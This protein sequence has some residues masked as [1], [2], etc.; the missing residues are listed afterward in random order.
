M[1]GEP[2]APIPVRE[3]RSRFAAPALVIFSAALYLG[4]A[5][6]PALVDDDIDAAHAL[7]AREMLQRHDF[8]VPYQDGIR[9]LI[10][11][12]LHF[13]LVAGSYALLGESE[14]ATRLPIAF[15]VVGLVLLTFVFGRRFF[16]ERAGIYGALAIATSAGM[17]VFTRAVIPEALFALELTAVFY[18]FLRSWTGSLDPRLGYRAAAAVCALAVLT[19]GP[20]GVLFPGGAIVLFLT[21][22]GGW[23][24]WR[25]LRIPS[26]VAVFLAIAAPWHILAARR[27]PGFL[28][29]YFVNEHLNRALGTRTPHDYSAVPLWLWLLE[30]FLWLFPWSAFVV[31]LVRAFPRPRTW[32]DESAPIQASLLLFAWAAV[33]LGFFCLEGG[34]RMEYYSFG[35]WPA[36]ALLLG[37]GLARAEDRNDRRVITVARGLAILAVFYA[38]T[39]AT[40]LQIAGSSDAAS[41][42]G[43]V[44]RHDAAFYDNAMARVLDLTPR[45]LADLRTPLILSATFLLVGFCAAVWLRERRRWVAAAATTALAMAGVFIAANLA[46]TALEPVLSS[47]ELAAQLQ[48]ILRPQDVVALYGDI[49]VAPGIAFYDHRRVLLLAAT[50]SNLEFGSRFADAPKTFYSVEEFRTL[51]NGTRRV[52][53]VAPED[54]ADELRRE[55]PDPRMEVVATAGGKLACVNRMR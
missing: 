37:R 34:S 26:S 53:L 14:L 55:L 4:L 16:G 36:L 20:I 11:P 29:E 52:L 44:Q 25:E 1:R 21:M 38:A 48:R 39:V 42:G 41:I 46:Y 45:A 43:D 49:R 27:A 7:V 19:R 12:P 22:T 35:A 15:A 54:K 5:G 51:W 2:Q 9:Y 31:F 33:I 6:A 10:R 13:W 23:R 40:F 50:G 28:W 8:V 30:H 32:R 3:P 17:Y 18:L 47:R 24:R